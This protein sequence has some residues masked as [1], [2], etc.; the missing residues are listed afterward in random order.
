MSTTGASMSDVGY[1]R[2]RLQR[3]GHTGWSDAAVYAYDQRLRLAA[4]ARVLEA[5]PDL[6][7]EAALDY[8]CGVGDFCTLL[9]GRFVRVDG[10]DPVPEV[11]AAAR[12]RNAGRNIHYLDMPELGVPRYDLV[13]CVTVLQHVTDDAEFDALARRL[14][15]S[16]RPG[17]ACIVLETLAGRDDAPVARTLKRRTAV[18][19]AGRFIAAGLWPVA[20]HGFYHPTEAPTPAFLRYRE[21][22]ITHLLGRFAGRGWAWAQRALDRRAA[23]MAALDDSFLDQPASPT[24]LMVFRAEGR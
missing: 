3:F 7:H 5:M 17:G 4:V 6:G 21:A 13:L 9:A 18:D 16:L 1:W 23:R 24:R 22:G 8:G 19:L 15:A 14:V 10:H 11:L 20:D 12:M 2:D